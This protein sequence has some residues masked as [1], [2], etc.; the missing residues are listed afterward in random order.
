MIKIYFNSI[1]WGLCEQALE[2]RV[3]ELSVENAYL[4][5]L[6]GW[7][8]DDRP[9][10]GRGPTGKDKPK[11]ID[12]LTNL[13]SNHKSELSTEE[14]LSNHT[15]SASNAYTEDANSREPLY[16]IVSSSSS[17]NNSRSLLLWGKVWW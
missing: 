12:N 2:Q 5:N 17:N 7:P 6:V 8:P 9:P 14:S 15:M 16:D 13:F 1:F 3:F 4:R 10:L 11:S